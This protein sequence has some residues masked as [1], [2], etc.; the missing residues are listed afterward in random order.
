MT[1]WT[2]CGVAFEAHRI[3]KDQNEAG[4]NIAGQNYYY[5]Y[6]YYFE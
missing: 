6:Y 5:Y 2:V 4:M 1:V 3:Q